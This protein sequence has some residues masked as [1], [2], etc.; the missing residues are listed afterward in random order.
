MTTFN[1]L[2]AQWLPCLAGD[3][4]IDIAPW[5]ITQDLGTNP[6][7]ALLAPRPDFTSALYQFLIGLLQTALAPEDAVEW[8]DR[9]ESPPPPEELRAAFEPYAH[10]FDLDGDGP[11]FMQDLDPLSAQEPL[12]ITALLIDAAGSETHFFKDLPDQGVSPAVAAMALYT[13]Q[14]NA[15]SGGVG[16]RTSLRGGGPLTTL[17]MARPHDAAQ[18]P[19]PSLWQTLWLNVLPRF[20]IRGASW[21]PEPE[22]VF[23][24]LTATRTSE[25]GRADTTPEAVH[26]LQMFW[27]MPRRIRLDMDDLSPGIC[28]LGGRPAD[29]LIRSFRMKNYGTNYTGAWQHSLS[30]YT[31]DGSGPLAVHP[32]GKISYRHWVGVMQEDKD[33]KVRRVPAQVV[34]W[35]QSPDFDELR[36]DGW[37]AGVWAC[38][39][40]MDN[41]KPRRWV[42]SSLPLFHIRDSERRDGFEALAKQLVQAADLFCNNLRNCLKDAWFSKEDPRRKKADLGM[43][44]DAFWQE[45]EALFYVRLDALLSAEDLSAATLPATQGWHADLRTYTE[46]A[47]DRWV[48]Y[49][50]LSEQTHPK[51]IA[52]ARRRLRKTNNGPGIRRALDLPEKPKPA[53]VD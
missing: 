24:W 6:V 32:R 44:Q 42:E 39:Y 2:S 53:A 50:Q 15:P 7:T 4:E 35:F 46:R 30:P 28:A 41:M 14:T 49:N 47:F 33:A 37:R 16:H 18:G 22:R 9:W 27:G 26:P 1:L 21:P 43:V 19:I 25:K 13:L 11:R 40:D 12:P 48:D 20:E 23:P 5:Q 36:S 10:A 3:A 31:D 38:G 45:T 17:I 29:A 51:R 52:E 8:Y 34:R